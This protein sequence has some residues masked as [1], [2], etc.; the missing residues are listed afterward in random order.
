MP[1][2]P[3]HGF[4]QRRISRP[5]L[6]TCRRGEPFRCQH[7]QA[8]LRQLQNPFRIRQP[9]GGHIRQNQCPVALFRHRQAALFQIPFRQRH[10]V[11]DIHVHL[12]S[13][14]HI[15]DTVELRIL[16]F[17]EPP[18]ALLDSAGGSAA[19]S[20]PSPGLPADNGVEHS[21]V[22]HM[23]CLPIDI[24][25]QI[26]H[27]RN[28]L[29][30]LPIGITGEKAGR[31]FRLRALH[32]LKESMGHQQIHPRHRQLIIGFLHGGRRT[33]PSIQNP[34]R[35]AYYHLPP[36][37][38]CHADSGFQTAVRLISQQAVHPHPLLGT[39]RAEEIPAD[40]PHA[41]VLMGM[42]GERD[43]MFI[44]PARYLSHEA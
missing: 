25:L 1:L 42:P 10:I 26:R 9:Y 27:G 5:V 22:R 3:L 31:A 44:A 30:H 21:D 14:E 41:G 40:R 36:R 18:Y 43:S 12:L 16:L 19:P 13:H 17:S 33:F 39:K 2:Q 38:M 4:R 11:H 20:A 32:R 35:L 7:L 15:H 6:R 8:A 24:A 29:I 23:H 34:Q 28:L 37:H